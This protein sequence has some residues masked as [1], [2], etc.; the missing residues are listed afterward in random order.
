MSDKKKNNSKSLN[1]RS[2]AEYPDAQFILDTLP[3]R[4]MVVHRDKTVCRVNRTFIDELNLDIGELEGKRCYEIRYSLDVPCSK[5]GKPCLFDKVIETGEG[6]STVHEVPG[7]DGD[8]RYEFITVTPFRDSDGNVIKLLE[9]SRDITDQVRLEMQVQKSNVFFQNV[10]QSTV[11]GIVVVDLRGN[12]LIF[13][14]G[15]EKLTG[16]SAEEI[17]E[18]GHLT[19]FYDIEVARENMRKMRSDRYGPLGKLNPMSM[20]IISKTGEEI[21]VTLSASLITID[22]EEVGSVGVFT[23]MRE[24][25]KMRKELEDTHLQLVQ[26]EKIASVGRMAAGMAHEI[27]NPLSGIL[28][29]SELLKETLSDQP[30]RLPDVEQII[31]QTLRCKKIVSDLLEFSRQSVGKLSSFS[32]DEIIQKTLQLLVNQAAFQDIEIIRDIDPHIPRMIGDI[33]QIQQV[34][35]NLFIN[36]ADAMK[37]KGTL[38]IEVAYDS[39]KDRF[40]TKIRDSGPGIPPEVKDKIFDIF[41]TTKPVGKGTG[42]GLSISENIIKVHGGVLSCDCPPEG[43]TVFTIDLPNEPPASFSPQPVFI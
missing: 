36:A 5:A 6:L 26:S 18:R 20:T 37:G 19:T 31:D 16:Y 39:E 22:G 41:F 11:D 3:Y 9:T 33:G 12:V 43:G 32:L 28:L 38:T 29:Y 4:V 1:L 34:F 25:L 23:D 8:T 7:H 30:E 42:L 21:P 35:T 15:M 24:I 17:I 27:N 13:N 14:E 2:P 10:I 40:I